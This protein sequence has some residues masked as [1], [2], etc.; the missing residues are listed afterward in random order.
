MQITKQEDIEI[1]THAM[2]R[3]IDDIR[4]D[5]EARF[6]VV[7]EHTLKDDLKI[8]CNLWDVTKEI[9]LN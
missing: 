7:P 4:N 8:N 9:V 3:Y 6:T 2:S 1:L 5:L